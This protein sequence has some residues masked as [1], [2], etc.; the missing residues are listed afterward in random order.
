MN[1][2]PVPLIIEVR[3]KPYEML[4]YTSGYS[5]FYTGKDLPQLIQLLNRLDE[6]NNEL[7][8]RLLPVSE[9]ITF[10]IAVHK[11]IEAQEELEK[12]Y[13][14]IGEPVPEDL[15]EEAI[16]EG[17]VEYIVFRTELVDKELLKFYYYLRTPIAD[18]GEHYE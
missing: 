13:E 8:I 7:S 15:E 6:D 14:I 18:E 5:Y 9:V 12:F 2:V 17:L 11:E 3:Y 10:A 1:N 4:D 16:Q